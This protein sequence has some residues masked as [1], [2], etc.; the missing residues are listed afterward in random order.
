MVGCAEASLQSTRDAPRLLCRGRSRARRGDDDADSA[1]GAAPP[2]A[3]DDPLLLRVEFARS[4]DL[5]GGIHAK[6][7]LSLG[8]MRS[9]RL[10]T[11]E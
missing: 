3:P 8:D 4:K 10:R 5:A 6:V 2:A 7:E 9:R 11:G 1:D